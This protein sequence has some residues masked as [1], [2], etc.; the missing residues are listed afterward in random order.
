MV[1]VHDQ[2]NYDIQIY[3]ESK[4]ILSK[5]VNTCDVN[6]CNGC[7]QSYPDHTARKLLPGR[8][9][10]TFW[11]DY[12]R[13]E[14][15]RR[16]VRT[17]VSV[18]VMLPVR[19]RRSGSSGSQQNTFFNSGGLDLLHPKVVD[20][21]PPYSQCHAHALRYTSTLNYNSPVGTWQVVIR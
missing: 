15:E 8:V 21:A 1:L 17:P 2:T 9:R 6:I 13:E 20:L 18:P 16:L 14:P 7:E 19:L 12:A 5:G 4:C 11:P 10:Q 3:L